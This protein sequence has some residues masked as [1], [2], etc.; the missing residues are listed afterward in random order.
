MRRGGRFT[1]GVF[2]SDELLVDVSFGAARAAFVR[3]PS[4]GSLQAA[5][6]A[7]Y[8]RGVTGLSRL[9]GVRSRDLAA[10]QDSAG[11]ALRWEATDPD[12]GLFPVLDA[13][14]TLAQAGEQ[15]SLLALAGTYR[16][17]VTAGASAPGRVAVGRA[18]AAT[19][20][21]FLRGVAVRIACP[22][23]SVA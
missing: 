19:I 7:A 11:L 9:A 3:L 12:G 5:S 13:D 15:A 16:L 21:A 22:P 17:P 1:D 14:L 23:A 8:G 20:R 6:E 4:G 10:G 18:A 2:V